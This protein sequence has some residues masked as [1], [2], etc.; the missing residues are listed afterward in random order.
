[1]GNKNKTSYIFIYGHCNELHLVCVSNR[2]EKQ[3]WGYSQQKGKLCSKH[4]VQHL[5][6]WMYCWEVNDLETEPL[7][8]L[9]AELITAELHKQVDL[10]RERFSQQLLCVQIHWVGLSPLNFRHWKYT[11]F[12]A[13]VWVFSIFRREGQGHLGYDLPYPAVEYSYRYSHDG[14]QSTS[15]VCALIVRC[16]LNCILTVFILLLLLFWVR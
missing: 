10:T 15:L 16:I 4:F 14:K 5:H 12:K 11:L 9:L 6:S 13:I 3:W 2:D 1:M 7:P 8:Q